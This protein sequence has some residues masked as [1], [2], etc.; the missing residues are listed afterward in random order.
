[1]EHC[2]SDV[3]CSQLHDS[4]IFDL[5]SDALIG[6]VSSQ[7]FGLTWSQLDRIP[8]SV[9]FHILSHNLLMISSED[10]LFS[11]I[12]SPLR[13]DPEYSD[14]LQFVRFEY[15]SAESVSGFLSDL[16]GSIDH[17]LWESISRRLI[18]RVGFNEVE[19]Q[20]KEAKSL[21][22]MISY[23]T[24]KHGGNVHDKGIVRIT[25]KSVASD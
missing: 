8:V 10:D 16:P 15:L 11:Y 13:S 17:R 1:M 20:L 9:L 18:R 23:L 24:R 2:D 5:F 7:F 6:R 22:G 12:S 19:F 25:S 21:D 3:I 14:L 4:P